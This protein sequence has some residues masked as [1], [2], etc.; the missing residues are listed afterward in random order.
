M[1]GRKNGGCYCGDEESR[2]TWKMNDDTYTL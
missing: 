1:V 2:L